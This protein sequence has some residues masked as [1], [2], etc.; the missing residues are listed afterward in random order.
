MKKSFFKVISLILCFAMTVPVFTVFSGAAA[1]DVP[2]TSRAANVALYNVNTKKTVYSK[3]AGE[4]IFPSSAVKMMTGLIACETLKERLDDTVVI[5]EDMIKDAVGW[6]IKLEVGM[7][8]TVEDLLYGI[9][10]G[11]G[12]DAALAVATLCSGS[13][14]AFVGDMND[15]AQELGMKNTFFTNPT[16]LDDKKM[17]STLSDIMI[18]AKYAA[19]NQLYLDVSSAMSYVYTPDGTTEEI[20]FF[21]RNSLISNFYALG[22]RNLYAYGLIAGNTELGGHCAITYAEKNGTGYICAV[23][24]AEADDDTIYSYSIVNSLLDYA[25]DNYSYVL[26]APKDKHICTA[27]T[28]LAMPSSDDDEVLVS[29]VVRDDVYAL[30]YMSIDAEKDLEYKYYLHNEPLNAPIHN[31]MIVGGVDIFYDGELIGSGVLVAEDEIEASGI[32]VKLDKLRN[33][34]LGRLFWLIVIFAVVGIFVYL[35]LSLVFTRKG[36]RHRGNNT[37]RFY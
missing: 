33:F 8:V 22:Y 35:R 32:L 25:F 20:K 15:K 37:K 12:N 24:N 23:M 21:N 7:S 6:R 10:C 13:I 17:Y 29:C 14:R 28:K 18:L 36:K 30:T 5:T 27:K 3:N 19:E 34:F 26:I 4:R 2:D 1:P 11:S 31:G 16:G 9:L